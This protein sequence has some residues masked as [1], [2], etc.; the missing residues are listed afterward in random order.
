[1]AEQPSQRAG[2]AHAVPLV[3]QPTRGQGERVTRFA[4]LG[5]GPVH[6]I[7]EIGPAIKRGEEAVFVE[8]DFARR[9]TFPHRPLQRRLFQQGIGHAGDVQITATRQRAVLI[10]D[11]FDALGRV[12]E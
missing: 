6:G 1:M 4:R 5:D 10:P 9:F 11:G 12:G 7:D 3:A 8:P 2:A